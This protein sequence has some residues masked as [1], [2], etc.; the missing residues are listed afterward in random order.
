MMEYFVPPRN[1]PKRVKVPNKTTQNLSSNK[2]ALSKT[3]KK[4]HLLQRGE[5]QST[6]S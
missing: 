6:R 4:D 2:R 5:R 3:S 1:V